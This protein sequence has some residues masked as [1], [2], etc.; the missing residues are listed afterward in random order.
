MSSG[1]PEESPMDTCCRVVF[2][3]SST[4]ATSLMT[5]LAASW[6]SCL[7]AVV[8]TEA[9]DPV[10]SSKRSRSN[11]GG[12]KSKGTQNTL[13]SL[14]TAIAK[15]GGDEPRRHDVTDRTDTPRLKITGRITGK[16]SRSPATTTVPFIISCPCDGN[17][18]ASRV[19][20]HPSSLALPPHIPSA[21]SPLPNVLSNAQRYHISLTHLPRGSIFVHR[22]SGG[23]FLGEQRGSS[24][25]ISH[26]VT[27]E[28]ASSQ[29]VE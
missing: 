9:D 6:A 16:F 4:S 25:T 23:R 3:S 2:T 11:L 28:I 14:N 18:T 19:T 12:R 8:R 24:V 15:S 22:A 29:I 13:R 27:R 26:C 20:C 5:L 21:T 1:Q 17:L 10:S 7:A